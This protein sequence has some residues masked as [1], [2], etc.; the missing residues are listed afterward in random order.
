MEKR[1]RRRGGAF[2]G[3]RVELPMV[4]LIPRSFLVIF[5]LKERRRSVPTQRELIRDVLAAK[6]NEI[7][8][9]RF[10]PL[11]SLPDHAA[12]VEPTALAS[13]ISAF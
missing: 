10:S 13:T 7:L 12:F 9:S 11:P 2:L 5:A 8:I 6:S 4:F 1:G 3:L